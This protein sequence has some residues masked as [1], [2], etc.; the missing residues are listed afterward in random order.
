[1]EQSSGNSANDSSLRCPN[2]RAAITPGQ[3]F[4]SE[5]GN[6]LV[7]IC[8]NC[9][10]ENPPQHRFCSHCGSPLG[11]ESA[12][13]PAAA[14]P[15]EERRWVTILFADISGFSSLSERL[16]P[17]DVK[18]F[19]DRAVQRMSAEIRRFGGTVLRIIGDEVLAVFGAPAAHEDDAERAVRAALA[20]RDLDLSGEG[21]PHIQVHVG[22]NTGEAFTGMSG[23]AGVREYD[24]H[25]DTVNTAARLR[26]AA[27]AG[28]VL[29][30]QETYH[31]TRHAIE[32]QELG[33]IVAKG[34]ENP[35]LAYQ[36][37]SAVAE[38][39]RRPM[40]SVP[41][42]GRGAE[43]ERLLNMWRYV[44]RDQRPHLVTILGEPGIGKSR[45]VAEFECRLPPGAAVWRGHCPPYGVALA[46]QPF[47][48]AL[49][50]AAGIKA[51]DVQE[52]G[53]AKLA[54]L[55]EQAF[56]GAGISPD[57]V[58]TV[59]RH[60]HILTGLELPAGRDAGAMAGAGA[61]AV[62]VAVA[63]DQ[64]QLHASARRFLEHYARQRPL[65]L[66]FDD[67]QWADDA[68][69][70]L[71]ESVAGRVREAALMVVTQA[72]PE[73]S[74]K[75]PAWGRVIQSFTSLPLS[76]LSAGLEAELIA[77]LVQ[78]HE[79][80]A[81]IAGKIGRSAGGNPL[82]AE[83]MVA[84]IAEGAPPLTVPPV[85]KLLVS[86]RLDAL[87]APEKRAIQLASVFGAAFWHAGLASL[88]GEYDSEA[89]LE[90]LQLKDLV[91]EAPRS[92]LP[93]EKEY[94]FKHALI[95]DVAYEML[96]KVER[97]RLH[98]LVA[99]W[100]QQAGDPRL[101]E[102]YD[103][104]AYHAMQ[105]GRL[106]AATEYLQRAA[107]QA[108]QVAANRKAIELLTQA[109]ELA[110]QGGRLEKRTE[111]LALRGRARNSA[112]QWPEATADLQLALA[113][114]PDEKLAERAQVLLDLAGSRVWTLNMDDVARYS[115]E[116]LQ[117]AQ[118]AGRRDLT[119]AALA[120]FSAIES[121]NG[122]I[123]E[124]V[125][126]WE[127]ALAE[128][129]SRAL[130]R[131]PAAAAVLYYWLGRPADAV[132]HARALLERVKDDTSLTMVNVGEHGLGLAAMGRYTE[133][134]AVFQEGIRLGKEHELFPHVAR[135]LAMSAGYHLDLFDFAGNEA[136]AQE[137]REMARSASFLPP[138]VSAA[139]DLLL[140]YA[141]R[142]EVAAF[143]ALLP[144]VAASAEKAAGFHGWLWRLRL[145]EARAESA[146]ARGEW[147]EA[148]TLAGEAIR[149][150]EQRGRVKYQALGLWSRARALQRLGRDKE[151]IAGLRRAIA[152]ARPIGDPALLVRVG[153]PLLALAGDDPLLAEL[154][155]AADRIVAAV[156]SEIVRQAFVAAEPV[157]LLFS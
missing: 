110:E 26:S 114:L 130:H 119:A 143:E 113:S 109:I 65:C 145:A 104:L 105:A 51:D 153:A 103:Q 54:A 44:Q 136:L 61:V 37:M 14:P 112:G 25:G 3:R 42:I 152:L 79:L 50:D 11:R 101:E 95:R 66:I 115:T 48:M 74:E 49:H 141:R 147:S 39:G 6:R 117:L 150:G 60:L 155:A 90:A 91:R 67:I 116:A 17:E 135:T 122:N 5:C 16:D 29:V 32:Y 100:L 53:R 77:A 69:L 131:S 63:V 8:S 22:A 4:C 83:E 108:M 156:P 93:G 18:A 138:Q 10:T 27:P 118:Q 134:E 2:C 78:Q 55:V 146:L 34:K 88:E 120:H 82:F 127:E 45:L 97:R 121:S 85:I 133:A 12:R 30:G 102:L 89:A 92:R 107:E 73:L 28:T 31:A 58:Q 128:E 126:L 129:D 19:A 13:P 124:A 76:P 80:P 57:D 137:A 140:N 62:A 144:D 38:P 154:R 72:R 7:Q 111:L 36:A 86:A 20:L 59:T 94:A 70:D 149:H 142:G 68:F 35:V 9:G 81:D 23:P 123:H 98:G 132:F 84:M 40:G 148:V 52:I 151:A 1:M 33:P 47:I 139:M 56:A 75:R 96:P 64:R 71:I 106:D 99:D 43:L 87:P 15:P 24:V 157:R 41:L 46:Y 21:L 125:R